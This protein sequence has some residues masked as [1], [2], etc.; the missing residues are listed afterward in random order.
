MQPT[1]AP[2]LQPS[3]A[4]PFCASI[5]R[6]TKMRDVTAALALRWLLWQRG[7]APATGASSFF[8]VAALA[9]IWRGLASAADS[10][11]STDFRRRY[12][13][14]EERFVVSPPCRLDPHW[15]KR[16]RVVCAV[17]EGLKL[18]PAPAPR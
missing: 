2:G 15:S 12:P 18:T 8:H 5:T 3:V 9:A 10:H 16:P 7:A 11:S 13:A 14:G 17:T 1:T 4:G 6:R